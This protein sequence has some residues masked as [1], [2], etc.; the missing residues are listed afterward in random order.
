M[1]IAVVIG[2]AI[3]WLLVAPVVY[4]VLIHGVLRG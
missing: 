1:G 4:L 2:M 3:C